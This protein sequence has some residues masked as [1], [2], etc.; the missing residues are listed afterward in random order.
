MHVAL[1]FLFASVQPALEIVFD[2]LGQRFDM[3]VV[4]VEAGDVGEVLAAGVFEA[5]PDLFVD[6]FQRFDAVGAEGG[7]DD[8]DALP[9]LLRP[10][11]RLPR[12]YRA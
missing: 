11:G 9:A 7:R 8:G 2:H 12:P 4:V 3:R 5:F 1:A 10:G 6:L